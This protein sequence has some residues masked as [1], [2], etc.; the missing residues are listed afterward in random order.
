MRLSTKKSNKVQ[1][2][3][4]TNKNKSKAKEVSKEEVVLNDIMDNEDK[5]AE[6]VLNDLVPDKEKSKY[7]IKPN[8]NTSHKKNGIKLN[9]FPKNNKVNTSN[10]KS[11]NNKVIKNEE[12]T[13]TKESQEIKEDE[14]KVMEEVE[15]SQE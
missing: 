9:L 10:N 5:E 8:S 1:P 13:K 4:K 6:I 11:R 15:N 14:C 2:R 12:S 3:K 7:G